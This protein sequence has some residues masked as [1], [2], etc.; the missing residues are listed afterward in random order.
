[1]DDNW[2]PCIGVK[3][4]MTLQRIYTFDSEAISCIQNDLRKNFALIKTVYTCVLRFKNF[5]AHKKAFCIKTK[6]KILEKN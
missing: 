5:S 6:Q 1:M 4:N 3:L 2:Q